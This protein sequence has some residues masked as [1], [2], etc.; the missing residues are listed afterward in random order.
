MLKTK[1]VLLTTVPFFFFFFLVSFYLFMS[2]MPGAHA[3]IREQ[4]LG[5]DSFPHKDWE[6]KPSSSGAKA[7]AEL[8]HCPPCSCYMGT[9]D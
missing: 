2:E 5:V 6:I 4:L 9:R 1:P 7:D 3:E 8:S